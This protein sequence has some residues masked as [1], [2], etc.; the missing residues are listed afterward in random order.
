MK[1]PSPALIVAA[2]LGVALIT[3]NAAYF[4]VNGFAAESELPS[5]SGTPA[6]QHTE[7]K[8]LPWKD[9]VPENDEYGVKLTPIE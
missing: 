5:A 2:T 6:Q 9:S 7:K 3:F 8:T 4:A 1:V